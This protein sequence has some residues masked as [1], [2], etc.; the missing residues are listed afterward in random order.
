MTVILIIKHD[1]RFAVL[2]AIGSVQTLDPKPTLGLVRALDC[3][4]FK[5]FVDNAMQAA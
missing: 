3:R 1:F 2:V 5:L 4:T